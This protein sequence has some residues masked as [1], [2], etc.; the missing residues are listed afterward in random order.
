M[1]HEDLSRKELIE[2]S[3]DRSFGLVFA[4]VFLIIAGWP[5]FQDAPPRWWAVGIGAVFAVIALAKPALL[6]PLNRLWTKFGVLLGKVVAPIALGI[7][8]YFVVTSIGI[9]MRLV[10][11]DPLH[12]KLEPSAKSYWVLRQPPVPPPDSMTNQF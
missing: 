9:L 6:A 12:L 8:F 3:S 2:G 4:C 5:V 1:A 11:K 7:L 10:G